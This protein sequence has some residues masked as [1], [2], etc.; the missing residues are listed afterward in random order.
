[1]VT[2]ILDNVIRRRPICTTERHIQTQQQLRKSK[3]VPGNK[4]HAGTL[5]EGKNILMIGDSHIR[6][7]KRDK[8]QNSFDNIPSLLKE[9]PDT[10]V[11]HIGSNDI[12]HII[13][14]DFN[15]EK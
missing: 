14:E 2:R 15:A 9:K 6:R 3:V 10:V 5:R 1:M 12:T 13:F 4:T 7:V 8:L 11:I